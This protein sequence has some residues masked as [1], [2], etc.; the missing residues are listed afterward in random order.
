MIYDCAGDGATHQQ[1]A[2]SSWIMTITDH[3]HRPH[4]THQVKVG[5]VV[6]V[7]GRI[8]KVNQHRARL[9]HDG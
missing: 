5:V 4:D 3:H 9:G 7:V 1:T 8:N 6:S 2:D